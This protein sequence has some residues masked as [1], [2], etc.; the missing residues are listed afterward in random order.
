ME[1]A[2]GLPFIKLK[3]FRRNAGSTPVHAAW[4]A[5]AAPKSKDEH[6]SASNPEQ[7][8]MQFTT[9]TSRIITR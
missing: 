2:V 5:H 1:L 9:G 6:N 7:P 4:D 3:I 8:E